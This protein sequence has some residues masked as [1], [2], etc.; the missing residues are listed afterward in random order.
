M[1]KILGSEEIKYLNNLKVHVPEAVIAGGAVRDMLFG[2]P[3]SDVDIFLP[4]NNAVIKKYGYGYMVDELL[5]EVFESSKIQLLRSKKRSHFDFGNPY[6]MVGMDNIISLMFGGSKYQLIFSKNA[7]STMI[8][9]FDFNCCR[10]Y[11][12]G[13]EVHKTPK[14]REFEKSGILE[15]VGDEKQ[16]SLNNLKRMK[17]IVERLGVK[18]STVLSSLV[19]KKEEEWK[20]KGLLIKEGR[21]PSKSLFDSFE[22]VTVENP[23]FSF[24][25]SL[26][27]TQ[28]MS[29]PMVLWTG[30]DSFPQAP[31][32]IEVFEAS[33]AGQLVPEGAAMNSTGQFEGMQL[34]S[35]PWDTI[36]IAEL[37]TNQRPRITHNGHS[38]WLT[39]DRFHYLDSSGMNESANWDMVPSGAYFYFSYVGRVWYGF[40]T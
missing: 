26:Q 27:N 36:R 39:R 9:T 29:N 18:P 32:G 24:G 20:T 38:W 23:V 40:K 34:P 5:P 11:H 31:V 33:S 8:G 1:D 37:S 22:S 16:F 30:D 13:N 19:K 21:K 3:Y 10:V 28:T 25:S 6:S 7:V 4:V 14:Y 2:K 17:K 12:D 15:F 35:H